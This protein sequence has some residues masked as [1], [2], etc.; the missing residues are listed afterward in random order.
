MRRPVRFGRL[1][2]VRGESLRVLGAF[3]GATV[4]FVFVNRFQR[5]AHGHFTIRRL[6][7]ASGPTVVRHPDEA[8][9]AQ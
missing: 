2:A 1:R 8:L 6:E 7:R 3:G 4:N 9:F 5:V